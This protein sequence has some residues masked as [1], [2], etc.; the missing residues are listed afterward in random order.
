MTQITEE[1]KG[2]FCKLQ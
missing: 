2:C 1:L